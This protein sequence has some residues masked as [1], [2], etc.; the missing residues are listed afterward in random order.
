MREQNAYKRCQEYL[1]R[2]KIVAR[3]GCWI[4]T[5]TMILFYLSNGYLVF[6]LRQEDN[7]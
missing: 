4:A 2:T 6:P 7:D 5:K 3:G 1:N